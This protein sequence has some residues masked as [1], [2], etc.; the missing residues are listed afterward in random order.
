MYDS[1]ERSK[2][3][4]AWI[5]AGLLFGITILVSLL[6]WGIEVVILGDDGVLASI[7]GIISAMIVGMIYSTQTKEVMPQELRKKVTMI[8]ILPQI[9]LGIIYLLLVRNDNLTFILFLLGIS[10]IVAAAL[11]Y[12]LLHSGGKMYLK[13]FEKASRDKQRD[14]TE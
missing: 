6:L 3:K 4:N 7:S 10:L 2:V 1:E 9:I 8:Y 5:L 14:C 12:W 13:G 11:T